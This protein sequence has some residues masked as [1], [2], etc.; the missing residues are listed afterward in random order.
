MCSHYYTCMLSISNL[1]LYLAVRGGMAT[2]CTNG[3]N[4]TMPPY[5]GNVRDTRKRP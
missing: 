4:E 5:Y 1:M 2:I 3:W